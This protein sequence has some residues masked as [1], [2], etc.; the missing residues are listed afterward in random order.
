[1]P[2]TITTL[3]YQKMFKMTKMCQEYVKLLA[4]KIL[5][6]FRTI[7]NFVKVYKNV[8][9]YIVKIFITLGFTCKSI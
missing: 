4:V 5:S 2:L 8:L 3:N 9:L 7:Q 1:M 6:T